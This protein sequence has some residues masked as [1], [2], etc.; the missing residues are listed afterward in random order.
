MEQKKVSRRDFM[1]AAG[2]AATAGLLAVCAP[3]VVTQ[4]V[5]QTQVVVQTQVVA[6]LVHKGGCL[7]LRGHPD[8]AGVHHE[9]V[10]VD[11]AAPR[12]TLTAKH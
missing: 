7:I 8:P 10:A 9:P 6:Q 5:N 1:K 12:H 11:L 4:V 3:Q 2:F